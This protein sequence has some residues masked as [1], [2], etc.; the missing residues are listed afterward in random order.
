MP[1]EAAKSA[2]SGRLI[3]LYER[4]DALKG[5]GSM[6]KTWYELRSHLELMTG[7][8]AGLK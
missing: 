5:L 2:F 7:R 1:V 6:V 3:S 4:T 8:I